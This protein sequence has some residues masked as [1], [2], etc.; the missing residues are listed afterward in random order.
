M[1]QTSLKRWKTGTLQS[2]LKAVVAH[3]DA[4]GQEAIGPG[5][6]LKASLLEREARERNVIF[7]ARQ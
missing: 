4:R 3:I 6:V 7:I 1:Y 2:I 5:F